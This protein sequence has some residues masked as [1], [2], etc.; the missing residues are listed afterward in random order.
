MAIVY[1]QYLHRRAQ[2]HNVQALTASQRTPN[3]M[4]RHMSIIG[5]AGLACPGG[6]EGDIQLKAPLHHGEHLE[7]DEWVQ[8]LMFSLSATLV[9]GGSGSQLG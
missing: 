7:E 1:L 5:I 8:H 6:S 9:H 3:T 2:T 4:P